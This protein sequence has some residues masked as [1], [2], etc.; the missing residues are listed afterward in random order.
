VSPHGGRRCSRG[1]SGDR[2]GPRGYPRAEAVAGGL[3]DGIPRGAVAQRA[4]RGTGAGPER[5]AVPTG[6]GPRTVAG[7]EGGDDDVLLTAPPGRRS[8][9]VAIGEKYTTKG[10]KGK[11][12]AKRGQRGHKAA[13]R[14]YSMDSHAGGSKRSTGTRNVVPGLEALSALANGVFESKD[15][16]YKEDESKI[17]QVSH[18]L[19]NFAETLSLKNKPEKQ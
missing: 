8:D 14:N 18:E 19:R 4:H 9:N 10:A 12:Y 13:A 6:R 11:A 17:L 2:A 5:R 7:D 3:A 1:C 15:T 16:N